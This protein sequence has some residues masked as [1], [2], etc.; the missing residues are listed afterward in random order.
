MTSTFSR[1]TILGGLAAAAVLSACGK[2]NDTTTQNLPSAK[3]SA[4]N[5]SEPSWKKATAG[6]LTWYIGFDWFTNLTYGQDAVTKQMLKDTKTTIT[7]KSGADDKLNT[8]IASNS[9]PDIVTVAYGSAPYQSLTKNAAKLLYPLDDLAKQ[10]DP[11]FLQ[12]KDGAKP[13]V[14]KWYTQ[15]DGHFYGYPS[16]SL[17]SEDYKNPNLTGTSAFLVRKD[18]YEAIGKP[19]MS[20]REGFLKALKDAKAKQPGVIPFSATNLASGG[21]LG[22]TLMN[23]LA[24]PKE[25]DGKYNDRYTD[26][27]YLAWIETIRQARQ[28]GLMSDDDFADSSGDKFKE[29]FAKNGYFAV[30][31]EGIPQL[32]SEINKAAGANQAATYMAIDGPKNDEGDAPQLTQTGL[33]GWTVTFITKKCQDPERAIQ[34]MEYLV[35]DAGQRTIFYGT[36]GESYEMKG[37]T[38]TLLPAVQK[39]MTADN[40]KYKKQYRMGEI[41]MLGNDMYKINLGEAHADEPAAM[42][43]IYDW[44][45]GKMHANF[46]TENM[47]P[48]GT[49]LEAKQLANINGKWNSALIGM[50]RAKSPAEREAKLKEWTDFRDKN[51]WG[52]ITEARNKVIEDNIKRLQ[53]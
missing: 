22:E 16:Y 28:D 30:L 43:Q 12:A 19:D 27:G 45:K 44:T 37:N 35:S 53:G 24:I 34:M 31:A 23:F 9:L 1:R 6:N 48:Q 18:V 29:K 13:D 3:N 21:A 4:V 11:Y 20:T 26:E 39:M 36:E 40:D 10:Y 25:V 2:K 41:W 7:W 49:T 8:L 32:S 17:T 5:A 51:G 46:E 42:Q 50:V 52:K 38:P 33:S 15:D 14:V 47:D